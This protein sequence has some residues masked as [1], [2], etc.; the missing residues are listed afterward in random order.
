MHP[1]RPLNL[2]FG[3]EL[4]FLTPSLD[5]YMDILGFHAPTRRSIATQLA[6]LTSLP[7]AA[8]C[9]DRDNCICAVCRNVSPDK[10]VQGVCFFSDN[11]PAEPVD[12]A[13]KY[14]GFLIQKEKL[15]GPRMD[16]TWRGLELTTPAF[17]KMEIY[18][19]MPQLRQV[20]G[21]M[22]SIKTRFAANS[23]CGMHLH[24]GIE[25]GM[26]L[27]VAKQLVTLVL[28]LERQLLF[29]LCG[30]TRIANKHSQPVADM[31]R[32]ADEARKAGSSL[33]S[34]TAQMKAS[35]PLT[36]R[37]LDPRP[38]NAY[39]PELLR[40]IL[41]L[42]WKTESLLDLMMGLVKP[43]SGR[44]AFA[45]SLRAGQLQPEMSFDFSG[46]HT[47]YNGSPST[48]EFR[49]S[50]MS[51][52][53]I[54]MRNWAELCCRLVEIATLPPPMFKPQLD[55]IIKCLPTH[56]N[57][58]KG[59][60]TDILTTLG[61]QHQIADWKAQLACYDKACHHGIKQDF[62]GNPSTECGHDS[63][64]VTCFLASHHCD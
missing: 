56:G 39:S 20:I 9:D 29:R 46:A 4:E 33:R 43:I 59:Q 3:I 61:L 36:I 18:H 51:F 21:A 8:T 28:L 40:K 6:K 48:F 30:P 45:L 7:F 53:T 16:D 44:C 17:S 62:L 58:G 24:V 10:R 15:M 35:V 31:S 42:V 49:H 19:G 11:I 5:G 55:R 25:G 13:P 27:L 47:Y 12:I 63:R 64:K 60:W 34:D 52:D 54:Y 32:F 41:R 1:N 37:N 2:T 22:R 26:Q 50:Q 23:S 14:R 38:W 57:R